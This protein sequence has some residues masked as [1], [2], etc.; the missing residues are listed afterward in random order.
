MGFPPETARAV[1]VL[2]PCVASFHEVENY[3]GGIIAATRPRHI[4]AGHWEDFFRPYTRDVVKLRSVR[5]TNLRRFLDLVE[6]S[7]TL[8]TRVT[9]PAPGVAMRIARCR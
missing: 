2:I 7:R 4:I 5:L 3:P 1:D 6:E 8:D 9:L